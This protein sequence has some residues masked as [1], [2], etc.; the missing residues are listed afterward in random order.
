MNVEREPRLYIVTALARLLVA[1]RAVDQAKTLIDLFDASG[2]PEARD[3][4]GV[5]IE[6]RSRGRL[7]GGS[8][9]L[10]STSEV[11]LAVALALAPPALAPESEAVHEHREL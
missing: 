3:H 2:P 6:L 9:T 8:R 4:G 11:R 7:A 10:A 1:S 5:T